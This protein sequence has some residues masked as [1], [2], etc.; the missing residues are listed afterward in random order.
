MGVLELLLGHHLTRGRLMVVCHNKDFAWL[1][2]GSFKRAKIANTGITNEFRF[3]K[4]T[5]FC[6]IDDAISM[7]KRKIRE[8]AK[9]L[10][11]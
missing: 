11:A 1:I 3:D 4:M 2:R 8:L 6:W 10:V 5:V 7:P 9:K